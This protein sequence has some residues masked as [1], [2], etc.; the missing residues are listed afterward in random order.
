MYK[1]DI[2]DFIDYLAFNDK[3]VRKNFASSSSTSISNNFSEPCNFVLR[4][5]HFQNGMPFGSSYQGYHDECY[6][7]EGVGYQNDSYY[8][9][10]PQRSD[11]LNSWYDYPSENQPFEQ[12][13]PS[14]LPQEQD[15]M[16]SRLENLEKQM[17]K[18]VEMMKILEVEYNMEAPSRVEHIPSAMHEE[19]I[20]SDEEFVVE[21][22]E[23]EMEVSVLKPLP[24]PLPSSPPPIQQISPLPKILEETNWKPYFSSLLPTIHTPLREQKIPPQATFSQPYFTF[25]GKVKFFRLLLYA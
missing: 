14:P 18:M 4:N 12:Q 2:L 17:S 15:S 13:Y 24:T 8:S 6:N 3:R 7:E 22:S 19:K 20:E 11:H 25:P 5:E 23:E 10:E 21:T 16:S 1:V 9:Y